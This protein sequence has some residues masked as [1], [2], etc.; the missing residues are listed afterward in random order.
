MVRDN[1]LNQLRHSHRQLSHPRDQ[2]GGELRLA[3]DNQIRR[4]HLLD[5]S[6][7]P[8][9]PGFHADLWRNKLYVRQCSF[10]LCLLSL[11]EPR[12]GK[13]TLYTDDFR[14]KRHRQP[15]HRLAAMSEGSPDISRSHFIAIR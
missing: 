15:R 1:F 10:W 2:C 11:R 7:A 12:W 4:D 5:M 14:M 9:M 6:A 3:G 8:K 13:P